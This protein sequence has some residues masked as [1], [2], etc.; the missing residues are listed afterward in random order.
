MRLIHVVPLTRAGSR[1]RLTYFAAF[2][3]P[4]G[5]FVQVPLRAGSVLALV[6]ESEEVGSAKLS[7]KRSGFA[8][9]KLPRQKPLPFFSPE[10]LVAA[11]RIA[12]YFAT[13][14]GAAL[15]A[16]TPLPLVRELS[17]ARGPRLRANPPK[18]PASTKSERL[19]FQAPRAERLEAYRA[20][21]RESFA[22]GTSV[23]ILSPTLTEGERLLADLSRGIES[24][25]LLLHGALPKKELH[26]RARAALTEKHPLL[27]IAT[28]GFLFL[29]RRDLGTLIVEREG[30]S[31][32][33][34][35]G[36]APLHFKR[37]AEILASSL[38]VRLVLADFPLSVETLARFRNGEL[39][40][41]APLKMRLEGGG[42]FVVSDR[43][44]PPRDTG[45]PPVRR[46]FELFGPEVAEQIARALGRGGRLFIFC[47]RKG[48]APLT[49]C[50]DCQAVVACNSCGAPVALQKVGGENVFYCRR[51]RARRSA[52]ERCA[53]CHSWRLT[54]LGLGIERAQEEL[55]RRFPKAALL[56]LDRDAVPSDR[57][58]RAIVET[59]YREPGTLLLGTELA[60]HYLD[61]PLGE[62]AVVS[63]DSL[64]SIPE[65]RIAEKVFSLLITLRL[66]SP[67]GVVVQTRY[68][69]DY[70]LGAARAG[71]I[72]DF[73]AA[74]IALRRQFSYPPAATLIKI[75]AVGPRAAARLSAL[76]P[77]FLPHELE[78]VGA[79]AGEGTA[80]A[81]IRVPRA[82]WPDAALLA[83]LAALSQQFS[84]AIDPEN[85]FS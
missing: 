38:G 6:A 69:D 20:L 23:L 48:L 80:S 17:V 21:V 24:Y 63:L 1:E 35:I 65:W 54:S 52:R 12:E 7:L 36:R 51:C 73:Y 3:A 34:G 29:P 58:A 9:R 26:S 11:K 28:G 83:A 81:L 43:R 79:R 5:T 45:A 46:P 14:L 31:A 13:N 71:A 64:L 39:E 76:R 75:S 30:S 19:V 77:A 85:L 2:D 72:A 60:L 67:E 25:A 55:K 4:V 78:P 44:T 82:S 84:V 15:F 56:R 16:L 33:R 61:R 22:R 53:R 68:P 66:L 18:K 62:S 40:E 70:I 27:L 42:A 47:A 57:H 37:A 10:H 41:F 8:L 32:Y 59:F 50:D 74:E 49:V